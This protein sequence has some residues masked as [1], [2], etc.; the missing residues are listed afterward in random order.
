MWL[1]ILTSRITLILLALAIG[2]TVGYLKGRAAVVREQSAAVERHDNRVQQEQ[3]QLEVK[4]DARVRRILTRHIPD[5]DASRLLSTW[6]DGKEL[7]TPG[8]G[9]GGGSELP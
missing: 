1:K 5:A 7:P 3:Q 4:H 2:S 9:T 6:P 8:A